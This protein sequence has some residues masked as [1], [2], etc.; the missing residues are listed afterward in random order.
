[1]SESAEDEEWRGLFERLHEEPQLPGGAE[2]MFEDPS[3]RGRVGLL[4]T[5]AV[6]GDQLYQLYR[7]YC[8]DPPL[9]R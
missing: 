3:A 4:I 8:G 9:P 1:M 5:K 6:L 2:N 7:L